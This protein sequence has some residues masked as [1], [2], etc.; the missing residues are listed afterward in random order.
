MVVFALSLLAL[1]ALLGLVLDGGNIYVQRRTA[2]AAADAGAL[3]GTRALLNATSSTD[4]DVIR[5]DLTTFARAN[6]FGVQPTVSCAYF[7]DRN[8]TRLGGAGIVNDGTVPGC[9]LLTSVIPS[10]ASGVHV[11]THIH[12]P[13]ILAA[14]IRISALDADAHATAQV[15]VLAAYN[16]ANVP[17]IACGG[18]S[19]NTMRITGAPQNGVASQPDNRGYVTASGERITAPGTLPTFRVTGSGGGAAADQILLPSGAPDP[20]K[21]GYTYYLKGSAVGSFNSDC[22]AAS[23]K[24]DGGALPSQSL[25][26]V[27]GV[28]TGSNGN[29]VAN[30]STQVALPGGCHA[31]VDIM[32]FTAGAPGCVLVLPIANGA[33][34]ASPPVLTIPAWGAFYVWCN[35]GSTS[36]TGCQEFAGQFLANWPIAGGQ[37]TN[38]W[39]FGARGGIT[40]IH[41]TS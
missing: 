30:I 17:L 13:T 5:T 21:D 29:S 15:G 3:A 25:L 20:S 7:V 40:V 27:P 2:V 22:G 18:G 1:A 9:P 35:A 37:S 8:G 12:F 6:A 36:G 31:G 16:A 32:S 14:I 28:L 4:L 39:T 41:L 11:D 19:G 33:A 38:T 26:S 34:S 24:F 10:A 23:N